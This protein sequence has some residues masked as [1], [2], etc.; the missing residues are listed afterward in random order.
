M[1]PLPRHTEDLIASLEGRIAIVGNATPRWE[2]GALIDRYETVIRMNNFRVD[3]YTR[4]VGSRT[5]HRCTTG[6]KDVEHR[7]EHPEF[8]PFTAQATESGN[9]A[10]YNP[11][12]HHPVLTARTDVHQF[13]P[14]LKRPS[15]GLAL[16]QHFVQLGRPV[17]LFAFDGFKTPHY[18]EP[19]R[20]IYTSHS[21]S[22]M[23][24]LL[25]RPGVILYNETQPV[26]TIPVFRRADDSELY[27]ETIRRLMGWLPQRPGAMRVL[28]YGVGD[29]LLADRLE[30]LGHQVTAVTTHQAA[31]DQLNCARKVLGSPLA[32]AL[33]DEPFDLFIGQHCLEHLNSNDQR[34]LLREAG[35][36]CQSLFIATK[37]PATRAPQNWLSLLQSSG[38]DATSSPTHLTGHEVHVATARLATPPVAVC[39][40][41]ASGRTAE[42][43]G[44]EQKTEVLLK[45]IAQLKEENHGLREQIAGLNEE[46]QTLLDEVQKTKRENQPARPAP[47]QATSAKQP[48]L[49]AIETQVR[50]ALAIKPDGVEALRLLAG[51]C[52]QSE[53][54][55]EAANAARRVVEL[56]PDDL[57]ALL[58]LA[59]CFFKTDDLESTRTVLERVLAIDP[60]NEMARDNLT[61]LGTATLAS[62]A[63]VKKL[64]ELLQAGQE[65]VAAG[66]VGEAIRFL[67]SAAQLDPQDADLCVAIASL[68]AAQ[69]EIEA[70]RRHL[71]RALTI[72]AKHPDAGRM[73]VELALNGEAP[74]PNLATG[75]VPAADSASVSQDVA[76]KET[77]ELDY[78]KLQKEREG[79]LGNKHYERYYTKHFGLDHAFFTGKRILDIG[80]GPRG[81]LE[82]AGMTAERVGLDP[83]ADQY[84]KLGA[85]KHQM[86]YV[87]AP[88]ESIPFPDNHF[89]VVMSFN[90]L[91]HVADLEQT[92]REITR[93]VKP[94]GLFLLLTDVNHSATPC[95]PIEFS[96][97]IT[98]KFADT[99]DLLDQKQFEKPAKGGLYKGVTEAV[100][101]DHSKG[102]QRYGILS[103][104]FQKRVTVPRSVAAGGNAPVDN[105]AAFV[106]LQRGFDLL[107]ERRFA[108]AQAESCRY[109]ERVNY[110]ALDRTDNRTEASP[111]VSVVIVAYKINAG[112]I[113][114]LDSIAASQNPPHEI[115]VVDNGGNEAIHAELARRPILHVRV[116]FNV[117]LAEGRNIGVHFARSNYAVFIDDD[118]IA[119]P[120][121]LTAAVEGF[122]SFD[123][124]AFRGKVLPK[125][126]HPHNGKARHYNLGDLPF[127]ADIDTEGNSAFRIDTW[128]QLEGQDP[129]LFGG[130]GV[131]LSRRIG[132]LHGDFALMYW[133]FMVIQHD[134]AVTDNKLE[135]KSS[136]HVL[137]REYSVFKHPDLYTFHNRLVAFARN[138]E[139]KVEGHRL[140]PRHP[141]REPAETATAAT[142]S[143][144]DQFFSICV[145]TFN[146][147]QFI[148]QTL[149]SAFSQTHQNF[150]I[151][152][153]DD[154]STD[155]TAGVMKRIT[156]PRVRFIVKEH[157]GGP[158]T[159]NRCIAEARG[160]FLVWLD[161]DD[162][163]LPDTLARYAAALREHPQVDVLYGNLQVADDQLNVVERWVYGD[164][165]GWGATLLGDTV[166]ENRIPNVCTLVRKSCYAR[167][168]GY[169]PAFPRAH[170][171][172]FWTRLTPVASFKSVNADVGIYRRHEQSLSK[173][174]QQVT[175]AYEA[176]AVQAMLER[177]SLRALFPSCHSI[178]TPTAHG[179]ARA[180]LIAALVM[181]KY[182]EL[183]SAVE[184]AGRSAGC[185]DLGLN[186]R[187]S[188][189]LQVVSGRT[190]SL[191]GAKA[192]DEFGRLV[193]QAARLFASGQVQPCA[194][195]CAKLTEL[196]PDAAETLLLVGLSLRRWANPHDAKTAFRCLVQRQCERTHLETITEAEEA[197]RTSAVNGHALAKF[198]APVFRETSIPD[199]AI[200][201]A[202]AFIAR[203]ASAADPREFL[204]AHPANQTP[205]LF[206]ILSLTPDELA[207][208]VDREV[209]GQIARLRTALEPATTAGP[210][211]TGYSFCIITGGRRREKLARQ[212]ASI[213]AL[214][215]P[216]YEILVGGEVSH[217]PPGV[218]KVA[219]GTAARAGR[220][221]KMRNELGRHAEY[222]HLVVADDDLVF[223]PGF[224]EGLNR[225]GESYDAMAVRIINPDGSRFWDWA[226][227]G[228][229]KGSVLLDYWDADPNAYITGGI[230]VLKTE[231][232][233][234]VQWDDSRGFYESE[235]V[236]FST[237]LKAAG[238]TIRYNVFA[239]V[240][241]D[242]DRYSRVDRR[243]Y[244][245]DHLREAISQAH[246]AGELGEVRR[247]FPHAVRIAGSYADRKQALQALVQRMNLPELLA[248]PTGVKPIMPSATGP[249]SA[250]P[251]N[252]GK[253]EI[254]WQ[255]SFLDYGSLSNIN[256]ILTDTLVIQNG[257]SIR[258]LQTAPVNGK[259]AKPLQSYRGKLA[260]SANP[261]A[262]L[263]VRHAW[264]PD[265]TPPA[266]GKLAVIQPWEFGSLP[267]AWVEAARHVD[268]FWVP[269]NYVRQ[270]YVESGVP[271]EKVHVLP[272]GIDPKVFT[273]DAKPLKLATKKSFKFLFVGGTIYRK[274][275]DV[276]LK[277]YVE[278]FTA[279]DDVCLV[280]KDFGGGSVYA[281]QTLE[282]QIREIQKDATAPEILYLNQELPSHELPG[283]YTA[284]DCL[285]HPYRGEGFGL[286]V[287]EA[288]ACGLPV[289][290]TVGGATDDFVPDEA[291]YKIAAKRQVFG[292]EISGMPLVGAGWLLEPDA[293]AVK[294]SL[295]RA[296]ANRDEAETKGRF[297]SDHA[298]K[299]WTWNQTA[300]RL[301]E[302]ARECVAARSADGSLPAEQR[303]AGSLPASSVTTGKR[304]PAQPLKITLPAVARLGHLGGARE[305][306]KQHK[307]VPA[308]NA[309]LEALAI[310][311]FHP[312]AWL[313]LAEIAGQGGDQKLMKECLDRART[314]A[315]NWKSVKQFA[316]IHSSRKPA[317]K[318][319]LPP[320]PLP[321]ELRLSVCLIAKNEE[322]FLGQC[323]RSIK[324][325]ASQ[326]VVVDTGSTDRTVAVAKEHGAEV[327]HFTWCDDFS[328][329][330]NAA[331]EQATGDWVLVLDA[332]EELSP[333]GIADLKQAMN[334]A[335]TIS[336]RLPI[337][338][339][340]RE[341]EG[342]TY[343]PRLF[344]NAPGLFYV[345]R[346]HEQ[347][348]SSVEVRRE[349]WG[350]ETGVGTA[351]LIHHGYTAEILRDRNK[352]ER[353]LRLLELAIE[354]I[355]GD[356]NLLM[357]C[358]LELI[359][360]GRPDEGLQRY[361]EAFAALNDQPAAEITPELR[362][363]LLTQYTS[364]LMK[365]NRWPDI[366]VVLTSTVA[367]RDPLSAS[368]CFTLGLAHQELH[369]W[370]AAA[371]QFRLCLER[372]NTPSFYLVNQVILGG[373]PRH[374]FALALWRAGNI[375]EAAREF[376]AALAEDPALL[377]LQMD[378][379]RFEAAHGDPI[380]ALKLFH[381]LVTTNPAVIDAWVRGAKLAL[382]DPDFIEFAR[383]WTAEAIKHHPD[384]RELIAAL[385]ETLLL[386]QQ[387]ADALPCW[388]RLNGHPRAL[389]ARLLCE[390]MQAKLS[391]DALPVSEAEVSQEF[392]NWYRR[393]VVFRAAEGVSAIG[394]RLAILSTLLPSAAR[395]LGQVL[396]QVAGEAA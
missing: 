228:G 147:A 286:P 53:R 294:R 95:E 292:R 170:D 235:D 281:G 69:G 216:A 251:S 252:N 358:G 21:L 380:A 230:C 83:L 7:R 211:K 94:G 31:Y 249:I 310:R 376:V 9:L 100:P 183:A 127:P 190:K 79:T 56:K 321:T 143:A 192:A 59:K 38:F 390:L 361:T 49:A 207:P 320:G 17:D 12:N 383:D 301:A 84:R 13:I 63:R 373:A 388:Q 156:D 134:Y 300:R 101:Y 124:H 336:W 54:W 86:R 50:E 3:G 34:L 277:A 57:E 52:L 200:A 5:T 189:L 285:A 139:T 357:N 366:I 314:L 25:S 42:V 297:A 274:G 185:A 323:L 107:K 338:D 141:S 334:A 355:P 108:E 331:L 114:C 330:R 374:C 360:S 219:L 118:A 238:F 287:L 160:E 389:A 76:F 46:W 10:D 112:L 82:W 306:L 231:V 303:L 305:L 148:E 128:R 90:S 173:V 221:G 39:A 371:E 322:K 61:A 98:E 29:S 20:G 40:N 71:S 255:G 33:M 234:R 377:P 131:E 225:F 60:G 367:R 44:A 206:A 93:V 137:M 140:L 312:E 340:D 174:R 169:N 1:N 87:A 194:Q 233:E 250:A 273:P 347:V 214:N 280:I 271:A 203:A 275:P 91:D 344:R 240:L 110:D 242:D 276:L 291:G 278:T 122:E 195:A 262:A 232:L 65:A 182:G 85:D 385:G 24:V 19:E 172:E 119:A 116:G 27:D 359:R 341:G 257:A 47:A 217:V 18:W 58:I 97:D 392:L 75:R 102:Q 215:L 104:K 290:V 272:N 175:T 32:L 213:H 205:L 254:N 115:I 105:Q 179:E 120:G 268:A 8:S 152:V 263:T 363:S 96:W 296:F 36:L 356:P 265:W 295:R 125:S 43:P 204:S 351:K 212:I 26:E 15:T 282:Q 308:W 352:V 171:Y 41:T 299:N 256:R 37:T 244:Q 126:D 154:G 88:S 196:R 264:P 239:A 66:K 248:E 89:D 298:R 326:V 253:L 283:L 103:A 62:E 241:H 144:G 92:V 45:E 370:P 208:L 245:F 317:G 311:P 381:G 4:L 349:E 157:S 165:H 319:E 145:P 181:M 67:E 382:S 258:R 309:T 166:I 202:L 167:V 284:C 302:L 364:H 293:D 384:N 348:F 209:A 142:T 387:Y 353:N 99:F 14:E 304:K 218:R 113:Q 135:T 199:E 30:K 28:A 396:D 224:A 267:E 74:A 188:S 180:W 375:A 150:E 164:Y 260:S 394:E 346:V 266:S 324:G 328:A 187:I 369:Q 149:A 345:S 270:V 316:R 176:Q 279:K 22:E 106:H 350:M 259:L 16:V 64:E 48:D 130:E 246:Q 168:G 51:I 226:T 198:L 70:A 146:R 11:A 68:Q 55:V 109:R 289:I 184:F 2:L 325:I 186:T 362:E 307:L 335:N 354:E 372:R 129:L 368:L 77:H 191:P 6:W 35:R 243:I 247:L 162:I 327:H 313:L 158:E 227:T 288:M 318:T 395:V 197:R 337:V 23:D 163:L 138:G 378:A 201:D 153:V 329:A 151:V 333:E 261:N 132:Q 379:A 223:D 365:F 161:S 269:S 81:S 237:R 178:G 136:R 210:R 73:L 80:C 117:I 72:D 339:A 229:T 111:K 121:Y 393:L 123:V 342:C 343:V 386:T 222:D 391:L 332:D 159:R 155:G 133:P 315:P 177:H 78:W 220:L 193:E 236:D